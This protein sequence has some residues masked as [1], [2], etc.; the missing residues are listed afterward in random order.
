MVI[1]KLL[2]LF[3]VL[4]IASVMFLTVPVSAEWVIDSN[5]VTGLMDVDSYSAPAVFIDDS[6]LKLIS[7]KWDG[8][9]DGYYW[10][11]STWILDSDIV[12]GLVNVGSNSVLAVFIDD[13]TLKLISGGYNGGFDGYYW[14][15]STW[16]SDSD[17]VTGLVDVG[18]NSAPVVFIDGS[19]LKLISGD[20]Y[21]NFCGYYWDGSTWFLDSDIV[22]GLVDVGSYSVPVVFIDDSILKLIS[23][24]WDG[25]FD[26]YYWSGSTWISDSDI[27]TGLVDVGFYSTPTVF[28]DDSTLKL[29]SG[30]EDGVFNGYMIASA[31]SPEF[32]DVSWDQDPYYTG[33][34]AN[35]TTNILNFDGGTYSYYLDLYN[36]NDYLTTFELTS[37][38]ESNYYTFPLSWSDTSLLAKLVRVTDPYA[39]NEVLLAYDI[40]HFETL[41]RDT[42]VSF[43]KSSY[44]PSETLKVTW[45]GAA[46]GSSVWLRAGDDGEVLESD[47]AYSGSF[48]FN[49]PANTT[50]TYY[51]VDVATGGYS[52]AQASCEISSVP[53]FFFNYSVD[54]NQDEYVHGDWVTVTY[55]TDE[56]AVIKVF[57]DTNADIWHY[58]DV[59]AAVTNETWMYYIGDTDPYGSFS[60][61]F[62][63]NNFLVSDYYSVVSSTSFVQVV[64]ESMFMYDTMTIWY[65]TNGSSTLSITDWWD[66][67]LFNQTVNS[68]SLESISYVPTASGELTIT[69]SD[70]PA[71]ATDSIIVY[72][73]A[74]P[75]DVPDDDDVIEDDVI[76]DVLEDDESMTEYFDDK[77]REFAP[78]AWGIFLLSII[79][80]LMA[81]LTSFGGSGKRR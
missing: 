68:S 20:L 79:L 12:T 8:G 2:V 76:E 5:I 44:N 61:L 62:G 63:N 71:D 36:T 19:T 47:V 51:I 55:S 52:Q 42:T 15:G 31:A 56:P 22:T 38:T 33:E 9:F 18:Y 3:L 6:T 39:T 58:L 64:P 81:I 11:G 30:E 35:I 74:D 34:T 23:G 10:S 65:I 72:W 77:F 50:E 32:D 45:S 21:G 57:D 28:I 41:D 27:V 67:I 54:V 1:R 75:D 80:W 4:F 16:I 66:S 17:I 60:V 14:S 78:T 73:A 24:K 59:P 40:S 46:D 13:S 25:G 29:I 43:N 7:G 49:V 26:G 69:L 37:E 70:V 48:T 53:D